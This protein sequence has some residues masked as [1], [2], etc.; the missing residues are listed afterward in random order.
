MGSKHIPIFN[1][2]QTSKGK[3]MID[4]LAIE[5]WEESLS[6][7][8]ILEAFIRS[9]DEYKQK[10]VLNNLI[11]STVVTGYEAYCK[12]R[13]LEMEDEMWAPNNE[14][15]I[16][17]ICGRK[18]KENNI[19]NKLEKMAVT[20]NH[21][22]LKEIVEAKNLNFQ[23][24]KK[25]KTYFK[26]TYGLIFDEIGIDS[27]CEQ[28]FNK[29]LLCRHQITHTSSQLSSFLYK[30]GTITSND[31]LRINAVAITSFLVEKIHAASLSEEIHTNLCAQRES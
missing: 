8:S 11:I 4:I 2:V 17:E 5:S 1:I 12:R 16:N 30:E 20:S 14:A 9:S 10:L 19:Q 31:D 22:L 13:F 7:I 15:L 21:S 25:S 18:E 24:L 28:D 6:T 29:I 23:N 27:K 3:K 26:K